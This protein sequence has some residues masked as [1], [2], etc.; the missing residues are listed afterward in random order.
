MGMTSPDITESIHIGRMDDG[1]RLVIED[2]VSLALA[3][4]AGYPGGASPDGFDAQAGTGETRQITRRDIRAANSLASHCRYEDWANFIDSPVDLEWLGALDP[5]WDLILM[6]DDDW[7]RLDCEGRIRRALSAIL[8]SGKRRGPASVTKI[9]YQKR[10]FLFPIVDDIVIRQL[11]AGRRELLDVVLHV[12][13]QG[14]A[15]LGALRLVVDAIGAAG[16]SRSHVRALDMLVWASHPA[17][18]LSRKLGTWEHVMRP[19]PEA[20][21]TLAPDRLE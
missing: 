16:R 4:L 9:L 17:T 20:R 21:P 7:T 14:R 18:S 11:G 6:D 1:P 19:R 12:R 15:N 3:Y 10:P 8:T 2:P 13:A 5:T